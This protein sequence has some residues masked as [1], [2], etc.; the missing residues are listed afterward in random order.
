MA[1]G[2]PGPGRPRQIALLIGAGQFDAGF[3]PLEGAA[4]DVAAL[5]DVLHKRWCFAKEDIKVLLNRQP[6][7]EATRENI[8]HELRALAARS[9]P[10]DSILIYFSGHGS[11]AHDSQSKWDAELAPLPHDSG[12]FLP[13]D[14]KR[15]GENLLIGRRDLKPIL[16]EL[17]KRNPVWLIADAC[18]SGEYVRDPRFA[19]RA[20][21]AFT[22]RLASL[23]HQRRK[24]LAERERAI[25]LQPSPYPYMQV[26]FLAA[27][28]AGEV[29][30][31]LPG[32][33]D[34]F[35]GS[36]D[37]AAHGAL[38]DTLLRILHGE[39]DAD[40]NRDGF[41]SLEEVQSAAAGFMQRRPYGHSAQRLPRASEDNNG[42]LAAPVLLRR[43][44]PSAPASERGPLRLRVDSALQDDKALWQA[45]KKPLQQWRQQGLLAMQS[46]TAQTA[47]FSISRYG[48]GLQ[49]KDSDEADVLSW[50][51]LDAPA[52]QD[53]LQHVHAL[54]FW[55]A[56]RN[57]AAAAR[58]AVISLDVEA[59][60]RGDILQQGQALRE[61]AR[62]AAPAQ[63]LV[64]HLHAKGQ[65]HI[66]APPPGQ[67]LQLPGAQQERLLTQADT[68]LQWYLYLAFD[69]QDQTMQ[70]LR[71]ALLDASQSGSLTLQDAA[72]AQL[73]KRLQQRARKTGPA[74]RLEAAWRS[75]QVLPRD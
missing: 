27:A 10:G 46:D 7:A 54:A 58:T 39:L 22:P 67:L 28:A 52:Q 64:L 11:S 17:E 32:G 75:L 59:P 47:E 42:L 8:L 73:L 23:E 9:K 45:L 25:R 43:I 21:P 16:L 2:C 51:A 69:A 56:L 66:Y 50:A 48:G 60:G 57:A 34:P 61:V 33:G 71:T 13:V 1:D 26:Q 18:Y 20:L 5:A 14:A 3:K 55:H 29:A 12:A 35:S 63:W 4:N 65:V 44:T 68:G 30:V 70:A 19:K 49:I 40:A 6:H 31:E 74:P 37:G 38:S 62:A 53:F 72:L 15:N 41:L 24:P 36:R